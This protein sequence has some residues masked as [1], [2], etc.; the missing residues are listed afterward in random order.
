MVLPSGTVRCWV[1]TPKNVWSLSP[2]PAPAAFKVG[3]DGRKRRGTRKSSSLST[4][5]KV[6]RL[7]FERATG[8]K[9]EPKLNR[10]MHKVLRDLSKKHDLSDQRRANRCMTIEDLKEQIETTISTTKNPYFDSL[11]LGL[12]ENVPRY[13]RCVRT[14]ET[15]C[16][17]CSKTFPLPETLADP[18]LLLNPHIFLLGILSAIARS[19]QQLANLDIHPEERELPL[20][21]KDDLKDTY[22]F[23]RAMKT[24]TGY[25]LSQDKPLSY[26]MI[27]QWIRR[28]GEIL[29]LEYPTIPYNLRYNAAN[30]FDR[31][32]SSSPP[33]TIA[34]LLT[35]ASADI[36]ESLRNLAL[37]HANS[38]PFQKHYLGREVCADTWGI[39]RRQKP[40]QALIRQAC[41]VGHSISKR[42]PTDLTAEQIASVSTDP[43]I[44]RLEQDLRHHRPGSKKHME[45]RRRLRNEKQ[46]LKRVLKQKIRDEWT[47][48]QAVDD[49]EGQLQGIGFVKQATVN[50]PICPQRP[51]Q[52]RLVEALAAP[53][54]NTLEGQ[55]RRRDN[56]IA[57]IVAYCMVEEG[58]T[59]RGARASVDSTRPTLMNEPPINSPQHT[60]LMSTFIKTV[61]DRPR[62][63]FVCVGKALDLTSDDGAVEVLIREF[64]L[65]ET[66]PSTSDA[67]TCR[68]YARAMRLDVRSA[69]CHWTIWSICGTMLYEYTEHKSNVSLGISTV[70]LHRAKSILP[71]QEID[72]HFRAVVIEELLRWKCSNRSYEECRSIFI[73]TCVLGSYL[74][75]CVLAVLCNKPIV[76]DNHVGGIVSAL[77]RGKCIDR[78]CD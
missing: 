62:R 59:I 10:R 64:T 23:R 45:L 46:R 77:S 71:N 37:D 75:Q 13:Q 29:G 31:S 76:K 41:S 9:L 68:I 57:A 7:V 8:D 67:S 22:I 50:T 78:Q 53:L 38:N 43:I 49:I 18:S 52:K 35:P 65:L 4:Y 56:A 48:R 51:A 21:L 63:C 25:E 74:F 55:Y 2:S 3:K 73:T 27:A 14:P 66:C 12:H 42:R 32:G 15:P 58:Q 54:G 19:E 6:F 24:F 33:I 72:V 36:S 60:A 28:V 39:L 1:V 40:Q 30:E 11:H 16:F 70:N 34:L 17:I 61:T 44:K 5:W 26:Q 47:A 69:I 20:P